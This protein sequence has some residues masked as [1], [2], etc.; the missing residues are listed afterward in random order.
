MAH[1]V[2]PDDWLHRK[3]LGE[4][5]MDLAHLDDKSSPAE[6]MQEVFKR[7]SKTLGN[8]DPFLQEKKRWKEEI[9]GNSEAIRKQLKQAPDTFLHTLNAAIAANTIDDELHEDFNL[10]GLLESIDS[11]TLDSDIVEEFKESVAGAKSVLFVHDSAGELFFDLLLIEELKS[12]AGA[13]CQFR[14]VVRTTHM[15]GDA[16]AEDA[17]E[18]GIDKIAE[19]VDPGLD[20]LGLPIS[21]CAA[22]FR[23]VFKESDLI[24]AKGQATYQ[25]LEGEGRTPDGHEKEIWFLFRVKCPVMAK[26]L[27]AQIGDL[28][29]ER[30]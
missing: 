5:M 8:P 21:E 27:A 23:E 7:T 14:S 20:C 19:I 26:Q 13:N 29:L 3:I 10:R 28:L 11:L 25:T 16:T 1:L 18:V 12:I 2:T 9:L 4:V 15:L 6:V 22:E 24:I 17:V 30:N